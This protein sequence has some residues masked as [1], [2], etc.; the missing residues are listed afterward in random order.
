R[1]ISRIGNGFG[2]MSFLLYSLRAAPQT[3]DRRGRG[4]WVNGFWVNEEQRMNRRVVMLDGAGRITVEEEPVPDLQPGQVLVE[5]RACCVSPGTELGSV[6]G[7]RA[8][9]N[10]SASRRPFG[11]SNAGI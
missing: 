3:G 4:Q 9:P 6:P 5:V 1:E 7:R 2:C 8:N 10:A 11:Y